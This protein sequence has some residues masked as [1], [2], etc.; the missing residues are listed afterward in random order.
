[1]P[2]P[3]LRN[4][5][6]TRGIESSSSSEEEVVET[7][8][9]QRK[10]TSKK[11]GNVEPTG[12]TPEPKKIDEKITP[13]KKAKAIK[14]KTGGKATSTTAK[15]ASVPIP[16]KY[17][18]QSSPDPKPDP[19]K[20]PASASIPAGNTS[21]HTK[22]FETGLGDESPS[23][24]PILAFDQ[25]SRNENSKSDHNDNESVDETAKESSDDDVVAIATEQVAPPI[26]IAPP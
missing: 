10:R 12:L 14:A 25:V 5:P 20:T 26:T 9:Q 15:Q 21:T 16:P 13:G 23:L 1:M 3:K 19:P 6:R 17:Q 24:K 2:G 8:K 11:R 18:N 7:P 4:S 22:K